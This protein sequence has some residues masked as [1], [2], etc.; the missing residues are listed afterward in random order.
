M[1]SAV[2]R[3]FK[4]KTQRSD[5]LFVQIKQR[6]ELLKAA[7]Q[8]VQ[9]DLEFSRLKSHKQAMPFNAVSVTA[10]GLEN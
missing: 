3:E 10:G 4:G 6:A 9:Q 5:T 8:K 2:Y 1:F 7:R